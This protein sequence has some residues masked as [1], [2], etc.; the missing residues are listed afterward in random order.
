MRHFKQQS[1]SV[2]RS[3]PYNFE[4]RLIAWLL[5]T[6]ISVFLFGL[7][8][9]SVFFIGIAFIIPSLLVLDLYRIRGSPTS[10][11]FP[12][13]FLLIF[14]G[15]YHPMFGMF[16]AVG[17]SVPDIYK[18]VL[19][20]RSVFF[21]AMISVSL[22][23]CRKLIFSRGDV[24]AYVFILSVVYLLFQFG[25]VSS[26]PTLSKVTYLFNSFFP[27]FFSIFIVCF[28][29]TMRG[30]GGEFKAV[31]GVLIVFS[32]VAFVYFA[33][34]PATYDFFRPD[35][36]SSFRL[37]E[38]EVLLRGEYDPSWR[39]EIAGFEFSRFVGT[40]PD[41]IVCGYF[42]GAVC[43]SLFCTG[44]YLKASWFSFL[45]AISLSKGAWL[46]LAQAVLIKYMLSKNRM[47]G[48][49]LVPVLVGGQLTLATQIESSNV[50][51]FNGLIGGVAS[52]LAGGAKEKAVG[53]GVG[54]GGNLGRGDV[55]DGGRG[56][57]WLS[58]GS[59]SGIGVVV[60]QLGFLGILL[61]LM[62]LILLCRKLVVASR[63]E[64]R[65][66]PGDVKLL[67]R[68]RA[69]DA[70]QA[71]FLSLFV[72]TFLQENCVNASVLSSVVIAAFVIY[73]GTW[74]KRRELS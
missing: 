38:G 66:L 44:Q 11:V 1:K 39:S 71:L 28:F 72:N 48:Y 49:I 21:L 32:S 16:A 15:S 36:A 26:A 12:F 8:K 20:V 41:P 33:A 2:V 52:V 9:F 35:L 24:F 17:E 23:G 5:L 73:A 53:F 51:H 67:S 57:G 70:V 19:G 7:A 6:L 74:V 68:A 43:F 59:E 37:R 4:L 62:M 64:G 29:S 13:F 18:L 50:V 22:L 45:L 27:L 65:G 54:A 60:Y 55:D 40:F 10:V 63:P 30:S 31:V 42:I 25:F 14:N 56:E 69:T 34:L 61:Y 47:V 46:F 58:S 3:K